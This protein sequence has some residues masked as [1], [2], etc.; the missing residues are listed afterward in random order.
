MQE[1]ILYAVLVVG[2]LLKYAYKIIVIRMVSKHNNG[3]IH[4]I[5]SKDLFVCS[6]SNAKAGK[7]SKS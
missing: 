4:V 2:W 6:P 1:F 7:G 5:D 3:K